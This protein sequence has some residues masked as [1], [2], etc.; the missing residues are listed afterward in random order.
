MYFYYSHHRNN[1]K[2]GAFYK[3]FSRIIGDPGTHIGAFH[4]LDYI[5]YGKMGMAFWVNLFRYIL[6]FVKYI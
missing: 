3:R 5:I 4:K 2:A 6:K 1:I